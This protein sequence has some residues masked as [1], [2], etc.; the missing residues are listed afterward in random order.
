M[1][2]IH[3]RCSFLCAGHSDPSRPFGWESLA[4]CSVRHGAPA[5]PSAKRARP[6]FGWAHTH[7]LPLP[8]APWLSDAG[9]YAACCVTSVHFALSL[10]APTHS[11]A[12]LLPK[13]LLP[14]ACLSSGAV[15]CRPACAMPPRSA[16]SSSD[17]GAR[18]RSTRAA[19]GRCPHA[20]GHTVHVCFTA[21]WFPLVFRMVP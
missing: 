8:E 2:G 16:R 20:S 10:Y 11:H 4:M 18:A 3:H 15:R 1:R 14:A 12:R 5:P 13:R 6:L 21:V 17:G 7:T 19:L 9:T